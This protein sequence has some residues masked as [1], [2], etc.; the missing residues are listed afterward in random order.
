[1]L[2]LMALAAG[3][4]ADEGATREWRDAAGP[5][6]ERWAA[7]SD[8]GGYLFAVAANRLASPESRATLRLVVEETSDGARWISDGAISLQIDGYPVLRFPDCAM[9][10]LAGR[11]GS[12][13]VELFC[14]STRDKAVME[15]RDGAREERFIR[16]LRAGNLLKAAFAATDGSVRTLA[17]P[18]R[19][20][21][22]AIDAVLS[23]AGETDE[24]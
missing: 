1:V 6:G 24:P 17:F 23:E 21:G 11:F 7:V 3:A 4:E 16:R 12:D 20:S 9:N 14:V 8:G 13:R 22:R 2:L 19:G 5:Y 18:L 15:I 10:P